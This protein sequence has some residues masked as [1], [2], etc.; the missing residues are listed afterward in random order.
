MW[1]DYSTLRVLV[2]LVYIVFPLLSLYVFFFLPFPAVWMVCHVNFSCMDFFNPLP[3]HFQWST[4]QSERSM[5]GVLPA[6]QE[7]WVLSELDKKKGELTRAIG[8]RGRMFWH[9]H[10]VSRA[11]IS[12]SQRKHPF[13]LALRRWGRFARNVPSG[14]E[15]GETEQAGK[16]GTR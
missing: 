15:R 11:L 10:W 16:L 5:E 7:S 9:V 13:L 8:A 3:L 4:P 6:K 1:G 12:P 2:C 14:E